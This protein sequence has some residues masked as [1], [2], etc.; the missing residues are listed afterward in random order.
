ML[1]NIPVRSGQ[2][3]APVGPPGARRPNLR[4]VHH[5]FFA[6]TNGRGLRARHV[7]TTTRLGEELHPQLL[8]LQDGRNVVPLLFLG[9]EF[10]DDRHA[11]REGGHLRLRRVL[12]PDQ[13]TVESRL[14]GGSQALSAVLT[15]DTDAGQP[16]VKELPLQLSAAGDRRQLL[17]VRTKTSIAGS[18]AFRLV[19]HVLGQPRP[20]PRRKGLHVLDRLEELRVFGHRAPSRASRIL[21]MRTACCAG[22]PKS[23]TFVTTR[24]R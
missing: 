6:V 10:Q 14:V 4:P 8:A 21:D 24:L 19:L 11:R 17:V 15:R 2:A 7:G 3:E 22:V 13:L 12:V 23:G 16:A 18:A 20:G 1:R 5:P 9:T